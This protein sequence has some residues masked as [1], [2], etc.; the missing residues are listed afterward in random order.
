MNPGEELD[1][2]MLSSLLKVPSG[3]RSSMHIETIGQELNKS[4]FFCELTQNTVIEE[5]FR[6]ITIMRLEKNDILFNYGD[7]P[8]SFYFVISGSVDVY[9][10]RNAI[11]NYKNIENFNKV[12]TLKQGSGFGELS[13]IT[14]RPRA[15][16]IK[17]TESSLLAVCDKK[18]YLNCIRI[19][20]LNLLNE[21]IAELKTLLPFKLDKS[22]IFK[23]T[24]FT[25]V[26]TL[27]SQQ[28]LMEEKKEFDH[29]YLIAKGEIKV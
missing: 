9:V 15:A 5:L 21:K 3:L 6:N 18:T 12:V 13:L 2:K 25:N 7:S 22:K 20:D 4:R 8:G 11:V 23:L 27:T 28:L 29:V 16:T 17:T 24:Y 19:R 14:Q 26:I 1:I 10:P